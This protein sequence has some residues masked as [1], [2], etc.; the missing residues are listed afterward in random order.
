[1]KICSNAEN[2]PKNS[3][4]SDVANRLGNPKP[5]L[6]LIHPLRVSKVL[7]FLP[8]DH[9]QAYNSL[10]MSGFFHGFT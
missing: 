6:P 4:L 7:L 2:F 5:L 9:S 3:K 8:T 1:M 10:E